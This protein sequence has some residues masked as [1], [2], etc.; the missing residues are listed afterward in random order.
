MTEEAKTLDDNDESAR[1]GLVRSVTAFHRDWKL[2]DIERSLM[3]QKWTD[4]FEDIDILLC[5]AV[6]IAAFEHD[7]TPIAERMTRFND[8]DI[9]HIEAVMPWAGL[10]INAYLPASIAPVGQTPGGLPVG[11][12][13][14]G[15]YLEDRTC[16]HMARQM[17]EIFGRLPPPPGFE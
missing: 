10:T 15:P 6:R 11:V 16:L 7:H 14:V 5:P 8:G 2:L 12:Q 1:A 4:Y 17:E 3:R 9:S 13:I